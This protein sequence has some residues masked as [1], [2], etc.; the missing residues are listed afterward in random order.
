[1]TTR[2]LHL[3]IVKILEYTSP[4]DL[5]SSIR[6][7]H[8][9]ANNLIER[10]SEEIINLEASRS[11]VERKKRIAG[12]FGFFGLAG[13]LAISPALKNEENPNP[14][15]IS[16]ASVMGTLF[17]VSSCLF[18]KFRRTQNS[19]VTAMED[20]VSGLTPLN[21]LPVLDDELEKYPVTF[22]SLDKQPI[23]T[24]RI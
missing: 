13:T 8:Q 9:R 20:K 2:L 21:P 16:L 5:D 17:F 23:H 11:S 15:A 14:F 22:V 4:D 12:M 7:L 3:L 18:I 10:L 24:F 1:M 6:Q 19:F